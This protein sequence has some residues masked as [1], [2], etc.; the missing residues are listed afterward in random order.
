[1]KQAEKRSKSAN[2][3]KLTNSADIERTSPWFRASYV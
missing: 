2:K 1:M 3:N